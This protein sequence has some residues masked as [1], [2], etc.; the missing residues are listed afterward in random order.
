VTQRETK[1]RL[2]SAL[3]H[4]PGELSLA[5]SVEIKAAAA[6]QQ[7]QDHNNEDSFG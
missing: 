6:E 1:T 3:I 2:R 7:D 4:E 5:A